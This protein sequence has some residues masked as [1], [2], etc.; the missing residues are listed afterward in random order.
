MCGDITLSTPTWGK[1][2]AFHRCRH[3]LFIF[4]VF[5]GYALGTWPGCDSGTS[6][7]AFEHVDSVL[8]ATAESSA[9]RYP[10][11]PSCSG[12]AHG[13]REVGL[14]GAPGCRLE[15]QTGGAGERGTSRCVTRGEEICQTV[16]FFF[17]DWKVATY[18]GRA[19]RLLNQTKQ[20]GWAV[21]LCA[22]LS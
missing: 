5:N 2:A 10:S 17:L 7:N 20:V 3:W 18:V 9:I 4:M 15:R 21:V 13:G 19:S 11:I 6:F 22:L 12:M 14:W 1:C 8:V 16:L